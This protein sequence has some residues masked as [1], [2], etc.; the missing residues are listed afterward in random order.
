MNKRSRGITLIALVITI[1]VLVIL[2]GVSITLL[3]NEN[4]IINNAKSS[5]EGY[6]IRYIEEILSMIIVDL[7]ADAIDNNMQ[8]DFSLN[9]YSWNDMINKIPQDWTLTPPTQIIENEVLKISPAVITV[10]NRKYNLYID[11]NTY[12]VK[13]EIRNS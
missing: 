10:D 11:N 7:Q 8:L 1:I 13:V 12:K 5:A 9:G 2:A 6:K 3:T 4:S